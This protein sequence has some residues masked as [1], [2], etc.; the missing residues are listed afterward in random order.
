MATASVTGS[1]D[2]SV[3]TQT[4]VIKKT[5]DQN[6]FL[7]LLTTELK[8]QDPLQPQTNDQFIATMAQFSS[9]EAMTA[10]DNNTQYSQAMEMVGKQVT[11]QEANKD[12]VQGV[13]DKA[14]T[15]DGK[16]YVDVGG[17]QYSLSEVTEV[18]SQDTS[19]ATTSSAGDLLQAAALIDKEVTINGESGG[20]VE[21]VGV[22]NGNIKVYV[23]GT[24]YD[25]SSISEI[26]DSSAS[27]AT[28]S[29]G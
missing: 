1:T 27:T 5:L 18:G 17:Q 16:V 22:V 29:G 6:D 9:L 8:N 15:S 14:G 25:L 11:V 3:P 20:M 19:S 24:P 26:Q 12:P 21:K 13:V 28:Q 23:G 7:T 10:V 2:Y 4:R